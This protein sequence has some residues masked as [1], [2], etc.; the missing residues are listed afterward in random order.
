MNT[1]P[2]MRPHFDDLELKEIK[3]VLDSGWV[4]QGPE[5]RLFEERVRERIG[6]K[7]A[8]AVNNCTAALHLALLAIG[9]KKGDEVLVADYTYPATGHSVLYCG[10][11]PVF[12]DV[13][14]RTYNID[15]LQLKKKLTKRTKAIIPVHT[16][17]QPV[18]MDPVL[19]FAEKNNI[20]VVEDAACAFGAK[21]GK[22]YAGTMGD[23]GCFSFH[24]RKGVTTG[25]GGMLVTD[26]EAM[27]RTAR[28]LSVF[29]ITSAWDREVKGFVVP[30][31]TMVGYNYKMSDITAAVGVV[32]LSRL[33]ETV[34]RKRALAKYWGEK[35]EKIPGIEPPYEEKGSLHVYQSYV[36]LVRK[37]LDRNRLI[38]R[39][40]KLG[41]QAQIGTYAS[42][43][44]P[45]YKSKEKCPVS[46]EIFDRALAL[47]LY[48][49]MKESQI[50]ASA[51]ALRSAMK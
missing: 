23:L 44:Q 22:K 17:G 34:R 25:E 24:A 40:A 35:L 14:R 50:D 41:V 21:Y 43:V 32:Q 2:L 1:I 4:S 11:K 5:T 26:D 45:V 36:S 38:E 18:D 13:D 27:A 49:D 30:Q 8:I 15:P 39:L 29:G 42:H 19:E 6:T 33:D 48:F 28:T 10:A 51:R 3:K 12:V 46:K 37:G 20:K 47:P 7:Y 16:F 9:I 31:F